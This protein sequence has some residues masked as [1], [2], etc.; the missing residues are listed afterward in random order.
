MHSHIVFFWLNEPDNPEHLRRFEDGLSHLIKDPRVKDA[1][2]G[3]PAKTSRDVVQN[4]Y[5][6]GLVARFENL[7][8]HDAYQTGQHHDE[9]LAQ[10]KDLWSQVQVYDL[11]QA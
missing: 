4:T 3:K 6:F 5:D 2:I 9:F 8:D 7:A 1:S 11:E 10:C